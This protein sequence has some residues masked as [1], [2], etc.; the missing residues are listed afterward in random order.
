M[1]KSQIKIG[2]LLSYISL[3]VG[4]IV[5]ISYTPFMLRMMGQSEYGLYALVLTIVSYLSLMDFGFGA[6]LVRYTSL[7]RSSGKHNKLPSLYGMFIFLYSMVGIICLIIGY[8]LFLS[9]DAFFQ[10]TL[11][12]TELSKAKIMV[13]VIT[14]YLSISFPLSIFGAIITAYE[15]F[16][17]LKIMNIVRTLLVPIIM[18][19]FLL[20]GYKSVTMAIVLVTVGFLVTLSNIYY[21]FKQIKIK[22]SFHYFDKVL[23]KEIMFFSVL[24]FLKILLERLYW[25][26][27]QFILGATIGTSAVAIFSIALQMKG[28]YESFSQAIGNLFLPRLTS[29]N[30]TFFDINTTNEL[31]IRVGRLQ[32]HILSYILCVY[33]IFGKQ[34]INFWAG[35]NYEMAYYDSLIIII[36]YSIPLI[37]SLGNSLIQAINIQKIQLPVYLITVFITIIISVILSP[38]YGA[39]GCSIAIGTAIIIGEVLLMNWIYWKRIGLDILKFW[40]EIGK[41]FI[42][43]LIIFIIGFIA[44]QQFSNKN[45]FLLSLHIIFFTLVYFPAIYYFSMNFYEKNLIKSF[46]IKK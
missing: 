25:S 44:F 41:I 8:G 14:V 29:I 37:Q 3:G 11:T 32:F 28:Y 46:I 12:E 4:F 5:S 39:L 38:K 23:L 33:L 26:S 30:S 34:F 27:G 20:F 40:K 42:P 36:P 16:V 7:F 31:F 18:I 24:V 15:R 19:P 17:F 45:I 43:S 21:C 35:H 13:L 2:A 9:T 10:N 1:S 22:V 6:A